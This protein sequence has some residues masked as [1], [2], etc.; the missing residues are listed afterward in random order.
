MHALLSVALD[1]TYVHQFHKITIQVSLYFLP[2]FSGYKGE[3]L[4]L[5]T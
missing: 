5:S 2:I 1:G 3:S 4:M